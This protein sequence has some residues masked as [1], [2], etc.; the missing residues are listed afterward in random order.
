MKAPSPFARQLRTSLFNQAATRNMKRIS[1]SSIYA[2]E[3]LGLVFAEDQAA[4]FLEGFA[5]LSS[6]PN[7]TEQITRLQHETNL[8]LIRLLELFKT[9]DP[10]MNQDATTL[11]SAVAI[12]I[13][14]HVDAASLAFADDAALISA[15]LR[16]EDHLLAQYRKSVERAG[17]IG[18]TGDADRL[19]SI[20]VAK[21]ARRQALCHLRDLQFSRGDRLRAGAFVSSRPSLAVN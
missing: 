14:A 5:V 16:L 3:L 18:R 12:E 19:E 20:C 1:M 4:L 7:V 17:S 6:S 13:A 15:T 9:A 2:S 8:Q 11:E 10:E 21:Q